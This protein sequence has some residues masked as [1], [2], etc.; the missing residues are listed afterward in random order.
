MCRN[1]IKH[2]ETHIK[3]AVNYINKQLINDV[4]PH[5]PSSA[6]HKAS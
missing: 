5:A 6:H 2:A 3:H 1:Y 4:K